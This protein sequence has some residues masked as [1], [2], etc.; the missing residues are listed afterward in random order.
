MEK[1]LGI[2]GKELARLRKTYGLET[3]V[4]QAITADLVLRFLESAGNDDKVAQ[5]QPGLSRDPM[6]N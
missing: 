5:R 3:R 6:R 2:S 4:G 1:E